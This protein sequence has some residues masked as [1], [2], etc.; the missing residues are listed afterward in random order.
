MSMFVFDERNGLLVVG[1]FCATRFSDGVVT[2]VMPRNA[3]MVGDFGDWRR[4][5]AP[6]GTVECSRIIFGCL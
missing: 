2:G 6:A 1:V 5:Q 4:C 3:R